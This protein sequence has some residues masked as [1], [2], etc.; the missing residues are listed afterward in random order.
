VDWYVAV[1]GRCVGFGADVAVFCEFD[2]AVE[3]GVQSYGYDAG[4]LADELG[5]LAHGFD[6]DHAGDVVYRV[7]EQDGVVSV[8]AQEPAGFAGERGQDH[9]G[10]AVAADAGSAA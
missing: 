2:E 6:D 5:G 4:W 1:G 10:A 8:D 7:V 9:V 3:G